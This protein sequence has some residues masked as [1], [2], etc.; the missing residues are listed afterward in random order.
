MKSY[1]FSV[2]YFNLSIWVSDFAPMTVWVTQI[3]FEF[4]RL[5]PLDKHEPSYF[6]AGK[7]GEVSL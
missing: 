2:R 6:A 5:L 1:L 7:D 3:L 4:L